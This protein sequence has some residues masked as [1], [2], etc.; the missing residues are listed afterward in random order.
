MSEFEDKVAAKYSKDG[1]SVLRNGWPDMLLVRKIGNSTEMK[2]I[3]VKS[4]KDTLKQNQYD[5]L[6]ALS[7]I[8]TVHIAIENKTYGGESDEF[9]ILVFKTFNQRDDEPSDIPVNKRL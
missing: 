8:L 7:N 1:W 9:G 4:K 6:G 5:M 2:A 3:E